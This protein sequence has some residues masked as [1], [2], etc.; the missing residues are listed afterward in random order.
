MQLKGRSLRSALKPA[1]YQ[2]L[3]KSCLAAG[4]ECRS[5]RARG[6]A[7]NGFVAALQRFGIGRLA[8]ILGIGA[9]VA[10]PDLQA[11]PIDMEQV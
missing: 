5:P 1:V 8:A 6:M 7:L 11:D 3:G 4:A 9:G 10:S 2:A